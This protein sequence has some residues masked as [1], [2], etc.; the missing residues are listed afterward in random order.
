MCGLG[1][2]SSSFSR[3]HQGS[4]YDLK[5]LFWE[6]FYPPFSVFNKFKAIQVIYFFLREVVHVSLIYLHKTVHNICRILVSLSLFL[7]LAWLEV[8]QFYWPFQRFSMVS[9]IVSLIFLVFYFNNFCFDLYYFIPM[10][11]LGLLCSSFSKVFKGSLRSS[12]WDLY[13]FP[14][15][16]FNSPVSTAFSC[17]PHMLRG[18]FH[19]HLVQN[20]F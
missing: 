19:F 8:F 2:I 13:S 10:L 6:S 18:C 12:I 17:V 4:N 5:I 3:I 9:Q 20:I 11:I 16:A 14:V 1:I 7:L 15:T